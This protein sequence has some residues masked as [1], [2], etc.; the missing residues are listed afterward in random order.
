MKKLLIT[1][2]LLLTYSLQTQ[3]QEYWRNAP[4]GGDELVFFDGDIWIADVDN[5]HILS[6][7]G[8]VLNELKSELGI[9]WSEMNDLVSSDDAVWLA[10]DLGVY[11]FT[12]PSD[13]TYYTIDGGGANAVEANLFG[14]VY[15]GNSEGLFKLIANQFTLISQDYPIYDI[16]AIGGALFAKKRLQGRVVSDGDLLKYEN[17]IWDE[18]SIQEFSGGE[19]MVNFVEM[20]SIDDES[21]IFTSRKGY[22]VFKNDT[23][24]YTSI[25][26]V[27]GVVASAVSNSTTW[28]AI[29]G[30]TPLVKIESS[31]TSRFYPAD[32]FNLF[33]GNGS[34]FISQL[35]LFDGKLFALSPV[36]LYWAN[37][38]IQPF[39]KEQTFN[40][41]ANKIN[42]SINSFGPLFNDRE[43]FGPGFEL[44]NEEAHAIF[45]ANM[46]LVGMKDGVIHSSWPHYYSQGIEMAPG[47]YN[48]DFIINKPNLVK[49]TREE[50]D[51][52]RSNYA[53]PNY[54]M[55]WSIENW[56]GNGDVSIGELEKIAPYVD[57]DGNGKYNPEGG[58]Y[59]SI[60]GDQMI[61]LIMNDANGTG[62]VGNYPIG[63][64]THISFFSYNDSEEKM[65]Q[66]IF[67][68]YNIINRGGNDYDEVIPGLWVDF[69]LGNAGDDYVGSDSLNS[70]FYVYNGDAVDEDG[71]GTGFGNNAPACGVKLLCEQLEGAFYYSVG[72]GVTGDPNTASDV[73]NYLQLKDK[74]GNPFL[75]NGKPVKFMYAGDPVSNEGWTEAKAGN[76]QGDRRMVGALKPRSL[77]SG[78]STSLTFAIGYARENTGNYLNNINLMKTQLNAAQDYLLNKSEGFPAEWAHA[79]GCSL[80]GIDE[81]S[82]IQQMEVYPNPTSG[83]VYVESKELLS[84][85][86]VV[87]I[88]GKVVHSENVKRSTTIQLNL[89]D[90][91]PGV[92]LLKVLTS[93]GESQIQK[94]TIE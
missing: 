22:T 82:S 18:V 81:E 92:Y 11:K 86:Q 20:E 94:L 72:G 91:I 89:Q 49:V 27:S 77:A 16:E 93:D 34:Y 25:Q 57:A 43:K 73:H 45:A 15:A 52:H 29:Q 9:N 44:D 19:S 1:T 61:F 53:Q 26:S 74:A 69:D 84:E 38:S 59:P 42:A 83:L 80:V 5:L 66:T 87:D 50:V 37:D 3:A 65:D 67:V 78:E 2:L 35:K 8:E 21:V 10:T 56:P 39:L 62:E 55:P 17:G 32:G 76:A 31:D 12:S 63:I 33:S 90:L 48:D 4:V 40:L 71:W 13:Y 60:M 75:E 41:D 24:S 54:E 64:E 68:N 36:R 23:Y 46:W 30:N 6:E 28:L 58:D 47:T 51:Y 7:D 14:E 70:L 79:F 88:T 85:V